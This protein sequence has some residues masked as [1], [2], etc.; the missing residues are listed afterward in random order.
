MQISVKLDKVSK[1]YSMDHVRVSA[2]NDI[3]LEIYPGE[4]IVLLGPSGS[5]KTTMLNLVGGLDTPTS[6][7]VEVNGIDISRLNKGQLTAFR[8][9]HIGFIF[10]FFNLIPTLTARENV[11]FAAELSKRPMHV[12][13]LLQGVGLSERM[14]HFPGEMIHALRE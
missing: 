13:D 5:G 4:F 14:D 7:R 3:S 12:A 9:R 2:L 8:R 10:Q 6:G 1:I 11:E